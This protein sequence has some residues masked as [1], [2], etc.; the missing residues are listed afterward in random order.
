MIDML[1]IASLLAIATMGIVISEY[2]SS[3]TSFAQMRT[4]KRELDE[5]V[6]SL[7]RVRWPII[8]ALATICVVTSELD[9]VHNFGPLHLIRAACVDRAPTCKYVVVRRPLAGPTARPMRNSHMSSIWGCR[10]E[11]I[12]PPWTAPLY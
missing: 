11:S 2:Q 12:V 8:V 10:V 1:D 4:K 3:L 5:F 9:L 6:Q 7:A